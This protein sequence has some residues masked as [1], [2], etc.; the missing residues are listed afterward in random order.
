MAYEFGDIV[1]LP[2]PFTETDRYSTH[3]STACVVSPNERDAAALGHT[4]T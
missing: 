4:R 1:L 2:F 3:K